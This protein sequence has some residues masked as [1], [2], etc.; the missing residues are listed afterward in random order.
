MLIGGLLTADAVACMLAVIVHFLRVCGLGLRVPGTRLIPVSFRHRLPRW[1]TS[2]SRV[3]TCWGETSG[4][5]RGQAEVSRCVLSTH[6]MVRTRAAVGRRCTHRTSAA[7]K[8]SSRAPHRLLAPAGGYMECLGIQCVFCR[9]DP[10]SH[11]RGVDSAGWVEVRAQHGAAGGVSGVCD[12][13]SPNVCAPLLPPCAILH[14]A[15]TETFRFRSCVGLRAARVAGNAAS[16]SNMFFVV[17]MLF[18]MMLLLDCLVRVYGVR[19]E[20]TTYGP[21]SSRRWWS[22]GAC[23]ANPADCTYVYAARPSPRATC[24]SL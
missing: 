20:D 23:I 7:Q 10:P 11:P 18:V 16:F 24:A 1:A 6:C 17:N 15:P 21:T 4:W 12:G 3:D 13:W 22:Y 14:R 19:L 2:R 8:S 5:L 9:S